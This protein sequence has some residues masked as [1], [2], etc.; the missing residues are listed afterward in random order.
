MGQ[1]EPTEVAVDAENRDGGLALV[2]VADG[3][4]LVEALQEFVDFFLVGRRFFFS[5]ALELSKISCTDLI[6]E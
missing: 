2:A 4:Q 6:P 3:V 5:F 1:P